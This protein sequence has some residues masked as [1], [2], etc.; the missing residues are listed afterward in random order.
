MQLECKMEKKKALPTGFNLFRRDM[1]R[2]S[3]YPSNNA[4]QKSIAEAWKNQDIKNKYSAL[5]KAI[6]VYLEP[7]EQISAIIAAKPDQNTKLVDDINW[8]SEKFYAAWQQFSR[9]NVLQNLYWPPSISQKSDFFDLFKEVLEY[10]GFEAVCA[11]DVWEEIARRYESSSPDKVS[12]LLLKV[13]YYRFLYHFEQVYHNP[14]YY[15]PACLKKASNYLDG[16]GIYTPRHPLTNA[17]ALIKNAKTSNSAYSGNYYEQPGLSTLFTSLISGVQTEVIWALNELLLMSHNMDKPFKFEDFPQLLDAVLHLL[18]E[19]A[20][21]SL[22]I[23]TS[24]SADPFV[25]FK[26]ANEMEQRRISWPDLTENILTILANF[27]QNP[28]NHKVVATHQLCMRLVFLLA[29]A[30]LQEISILAGDVISSVA[31]QLDVSAIPAWT[32][33][34]IQ[35]IER[36]ISSENVISQQQALKLLTLISSRQNNSVFFVSNFFPTSIFQSCLAKI[37]LAV[38]PSD[39]SEQACQERTI[40][41]LAVEG[42]FHIVKSGE[43]VRMRLCRETDCVQ[44]LV[45]ILN[46]GQNDCV[47][48]EA[49]EEFKRRIRRTAAAAIGLI[50]EVKEN[51]KV[52]EEFEAKIFEACAAHFEVA[53]FLSALLL[54]LPLLDTSASQ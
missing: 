53:Y 15:K 3:T 22:G 2:L 20:F 26:T 50:Y 28:K 33:T 14:L 30:D 51:Q 6:E 7:E 21:S 44:R 24:S 19:Y 47:D 18:R 10:G 13:F 41:L 9:E 38:S 48:D 52:F 31:S 34:L 49:I 40:L 12:G 5:A 37:N 42:I 25:T 1:Q 43:K 11:Q 17:S 4:L 45:S 35:W 36:S 29:V 27:A 46:Y 39:T 8:N 16:D 23:R 54:L 32:S